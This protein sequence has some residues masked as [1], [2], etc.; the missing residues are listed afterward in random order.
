MLPAAAREDV[1]VVPTK[2]S[3]LMVYPYSKTS[4]FE[5]VTAIEF[6]VTIPKKV[7][8]EMDGDCECDKCLEDSGMGKRYNIYEG[9]KLRTN[10]CIDDPV[11]DLKKQPIT[12]KLI[13]PKCFDD[14]K[15]IGTDNQIIT[16][17]RNDTN[18][19]IDNT[20]GHFEDPGGDNYQEVE[21]LESSRYA[22][23][24]DL[25]ELSIQNVT[26]IHHPFHLHGFF[27]QLCKM[28]SIEGEYPDAK[29]VDLLHTWDHNEFVDTFNVPPFT[30]ITFRVKL[31]DKPKR[32]GSPGG[33]I[34]RWLH[35]CHIVNHAAS[36]MISELVVVKDNPCDTDTDCKCKCKFCIDHCN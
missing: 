19:L 30:R 20:A 16:F 21:H 18:M 31:N 17:N 34:G 14:P 26:T 33:G 11:I 35:H 23:L 6:N 2:G 25:L 32:D 15:M 7:R 10:E 1:V 24:G 36:G 13:D 3:K 12:G 5:T 22:K 27:V 8:W 4:E 28:E 9:M 29:V